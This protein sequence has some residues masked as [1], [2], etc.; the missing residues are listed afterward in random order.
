M[1]A[2]R[3]ILSHARLAEIKQI[4]QEPALRQTIRLAAAEAAGDRSSTPEPSSEKLEQRSRQVLERL[5]LS[6]SFL[7][8]TMVAISNSLWREAFGAVPYHRRL[9]LLPH[10]LSDREACQGCYDADGLSCAGCGRCPICDL[11]AEAERL[12]YQVIVAE[13]TNAVLNLVLEGRADA[14]LGVACMESLARS[15]SRVAELGIPYLAVPLLKDG[16]SDTTAE[17]PHIR[18]LLICRSNAPPAVIPGYVPLLRQTVRLFQEPRFSQ[19]LGVVLGSASAQGDGLNAAERIALGWLRDGGKRL[20]PF[21]T[22]AAYAIARHGLAAIQSDAN[23]ENLTP[24]FVRLLAIAIESL[25][26]ASLV[27]DD[28]EDNDPFRYGQETIHRKHGLGPAVNV[29]DYLIG[30]GYRLI[31]S[32]AD[33]LGSDCAADILAELS[34]AHLELCRGQG[35]EL[36]WLGRPQRIPTPLEVMTVYALKTAPAFEAA[37]YC[38]LR[39]AKVTFDP[40]LLRRFC[41]DLGEAFQILDDLDDWRADDRDTIT[42][43]ADALSARPTLLRALAA[44]AGAGAAL[45]S[46]T[47]V[48][49]HERSEPR[50]EQIRQ[51]YLHSGAFKLAEQMFHK[52]RHRALTAAGEFPTDDLCRL[53]RF[54]VQMVL[55]GRLV[56]PEGEP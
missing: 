23:L 38:G 35:A 16:C 9:F 12:G 52:L 40:A 53:A 42:R 34:R 39:A 4:P 47:P 3:F 14:L 49:P 11:K 36:Y 21:V 27:H 25:H 51:I 26:K 43:G 54:L 56:M 10:C 32:Q 28:I 15:F 37:L 45:T 13:G 33:K 18:E 19:T 46:I 2:D 41:T 22:L 7:G 1:A 17:L 31:A 29:G 30:L 24:P 20:R 44:E 8:F 6:E 50:V 55:P 5:G 48:S